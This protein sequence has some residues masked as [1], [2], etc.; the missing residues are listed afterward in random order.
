MEQSAQQI[1]EARLKNIGA[2]NKAQAADAANAAAPEEEKKEE[3]VP[4]APEVINSRRE[5]VVA[6]ESKQSS[7]S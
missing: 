1:R 3:P 6:E 5:R 4:V 2:A 7:G